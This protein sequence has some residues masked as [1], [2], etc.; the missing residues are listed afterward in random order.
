MDY[1][2]LYTVLYSLIHISVPQTTPEEHRM[3]DCERMDEL[4]GRIIYRVCYSANLFLLHNGAFNISLYPEDSTCGRVREPY[5]TL[6]SDPFL[7]H[8]I[9]TLFCAIQL[10]EV[11]LHV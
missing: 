3:N 5:C 10:I 7:E 2:V 1:S 8:R 9:S 6:V 11:W 4:D